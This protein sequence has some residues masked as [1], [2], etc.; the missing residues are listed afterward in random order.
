MDLSAIY[1]LRKDNGG[2]LREWQ[3]LPRNPAFRRALGLWTS[4]LQ[5]RKKTPVHTITLSVDAVI[6]PAILHTCVSGAQMH[7]RK[8]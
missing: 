8:V 1:L 5:T 4:G 2:A 7:V 3:R 6:D